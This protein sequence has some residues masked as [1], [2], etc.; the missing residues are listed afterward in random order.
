[1][2]KIG[3]AIEGISLNGKEWLLDSN[4]ELMTFDSVNDAKEFLKENG[5]DSLS[6]DELED[7]FFYEEVEVN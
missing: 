1:M 4:N 6:E 2:I 7:A 3:R 5:F